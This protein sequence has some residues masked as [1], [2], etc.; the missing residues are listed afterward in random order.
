M[1]R[2]LL[3]STVAAAGLF[4]AECPAGAADLAVAPAPVIAPV[5]VFSWTG[6]YVGGN[7]GGASSRYKGLVHASPAEPFT[8]SAGDFLNI[9]DTA[10]S[11]VGGGQ[12]GFNWQTGPW[13]LGLEGDLDAAGVERT[14]R[15]PGS[16]LF[17]LG[18]TFRFEND[19][20]ASVRA[21]GGVAFD[22]WLAYATGGVAWAGVSAQGTYAPNTYTDNT[23]TNM[24][25]FSVR[26]QPGITVDAPGTFGSDRQTL[27]GGTVG[28]GV[29]YALTDNVSLGVEYRYT[30][31]GAKTFNLGGIPLVLATSNVTARLEEQTSQVTARLNIK[32]GGLLGLG[33][34]AGIDG[35]A[36]WWNGLFAAAPA[37]PPVA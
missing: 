3:L 17:V 9:T 18:H 4:A 28:A 24:G 21:R 10:G 1:R 13:V 31:F 2:Q 37:A 33:S 8:S 20:Q 34:P 23:S 35:L 19:W 22:R 32:Y 16:S 12:L 7:L 11:F 26:G 36:S 27:V 14:I 25:A 6:W 29:E 15:G 5:P 30:R